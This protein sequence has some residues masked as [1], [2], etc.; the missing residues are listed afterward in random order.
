VPFDAL[1]PLGPDAC[2]SDPSRTCR[3]W[4]LKLRALNGERDKLSRR[5]L[6]LVSVG[7][8]ASPEPGWRSLDG[9]YFDEQQIQAD[10]VLKALAGIVGS[11]QAFEF[12]A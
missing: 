5:D 2:R 10:P 6:E 9:A 1:E 8:T 7:V 3:Y 11:Q 4:R 12:L